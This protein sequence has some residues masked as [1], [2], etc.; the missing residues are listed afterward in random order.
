MSLVTGAGRPGLLRG[1][2]GSGGDSGVIFSGIRHGAHTLPRSLAAVA[3]GLHGPVRL[4]VPFNVFVRKL[5]PN[6]PKNK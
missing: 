2:R 5:S 4:F 6:S 1:I 3:P